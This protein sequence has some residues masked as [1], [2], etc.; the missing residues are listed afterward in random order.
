MAEIIASSTYLPRLRLP[1]AAIT[2]AW[3]QARGSGE[4]AVANYDEDAFTM[5]TEAAQ[6]ALALSPVTPDAFYFA[7]T[8]A[9]YREKQLA[10][11]AATV[12]DLSRTTRTAD[13]GGSARAGLAALV[14]ASEA[15]GSGRIRAAIVAAAEARLA[16][17]ESEAE[18]LFGDGAAAVV[19]ADRGGIAEIVDASSVS[20][21]FTYFW[22]TEG[23]SF[24]RGHVGKFSQTYGYARDMVEV[25]QIL[26]ERN[27]LAASEI[28]KLVLHSPEPR[29]AL[30]VS[31]RLGFDERSQLVVPPVT[32]IGSLGSA[33][34]LLG[35]QMALEAASPDQWVIVAAYGEGADAL[36]LRTTSQVAEKP[37]RKVEDWIAARLPLESYAKYLKYRRVLPREETGEAITNILEFKE[38]RQDIRLYGSR[39]SKCGTVQYPLA[40]V[41]IR[42]KGQET[43]EEVKLS[44]EGTVFT[45]TIDHLIANVEHPLPMVVLDLNDGGRLYLQVTDFQEDEVR[46]GAPMRLTYRRLHE[47]GSNFNYFWKAR[48]VR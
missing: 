24:V 8:S 13:F 15:I 37:G 6:S 35:L 34:A 21:E 7:S 47:G 43:L 5:A 18:G 1:R 25:V 46:I 42:C 3:G 11:F 19:V 17:P 28:A 27:R 20:E 38:L 29:A 44:R 32:Q 40:R 9:P 48:P 33:D 41:C 39:C 23:D 10:A 2:A 30:E 31:K 4:I 22:R 14:A 45:F 36:L 26:L 16:E 12:C